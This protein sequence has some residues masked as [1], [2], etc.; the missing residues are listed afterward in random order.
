MDRFT[1]A[2]LVQPAGANIS[3]AVTIQEKLMKYWNET[4]FS[5]RAVN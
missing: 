4:F 3:V 2:I 1:P 5:A